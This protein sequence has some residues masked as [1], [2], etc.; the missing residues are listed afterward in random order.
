[1]AEPHVLSALFDKYACVM[2]ELRRCESEAEK[3]RASL[4]SIE[5]TIKLFKPDWTGDGIKPH[6]AHRPSRWPKGSGG[7]RMALTILREAAEPLTTRQIVVRVL[8]RHKMPEPHYDEVKLICSS[9]NSAF[10]NKAAKG[11]LVMVEGKPVK[12]TLTPP[13]ANT[14]S[15]P[16]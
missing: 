12:W 5:A 14:P 13:A 4:A 9:F 8:E 10:R 6:K 2:G 15:M 1:M 16:D 11:G 7:M 3:H